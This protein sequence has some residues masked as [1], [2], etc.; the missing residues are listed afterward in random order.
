MRSR[1]PLGELF[2]TLS[3][4]TLDSFPTQR[5]G[6]IKSEKVIQISRWLFDA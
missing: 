3:I 5:S 4:S 1:L 2:D 6:C